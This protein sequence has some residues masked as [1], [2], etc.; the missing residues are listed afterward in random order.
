VKIEI[1]VSC[2]RE[3]P[4]VTNSA[5]LHDD[6]FTQGSCTLTW[7]CNKLNNAVINYIVP[8]P[9]EIMCNCPF[10]KKKNKGTL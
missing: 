9:N 3:C 10:K 8:N 6:P 7:Y 4:Y 2:C 1:E 5:Q